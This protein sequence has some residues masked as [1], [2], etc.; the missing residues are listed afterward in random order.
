MVRA[1]R[2]VSI[3]TEG[4]RVACPVPR[5]GIGLWEGTCLTVRG[6]LDARRTRDVQDASH[7]HS[8]HRLMAA[9][10]RH[11]GEATRRI[12]E[13]LSAVDRDLAPLE[14]LI[15]ESIPVGPDAPTSAELAALPVEDRAAWAARVRAAHAAR[16]EHRATE[17]RQ[18]DARVRIAVLHSIREGLDV[19]GADVRR[20]WREAYEM[21]AARY[22]R[23][24]F[25]RR[26]GTMAI[27]PAVAGYRGFEQPTVVRRS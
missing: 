14:A 13:A 23:A 2:V 12:D 21:R 16:A 4:Y 24:R 22:T 1:S 15:A 11:E 10:R 27:E 25:G 9:H 5:Y 20:Q 3:G 7:T 19:E 26:G 6:W 8:L 17:G 18:A